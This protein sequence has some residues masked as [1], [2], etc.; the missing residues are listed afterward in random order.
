[1]LKGSVGEQDSIGPCSVCGTYDELPELPGRASRCC[2]SCGADLATVALLT[3]EID[4]A[5]LSGR[6]A[7]NLIEELN[8]LSARVL[9]RSQSA[10]SGSIFF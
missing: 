3:E 8:E 2:L 7:E 6:D 10:D 1:M 5:T 4:A 9:A